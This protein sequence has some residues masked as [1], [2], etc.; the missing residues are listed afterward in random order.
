ML[1]L[2]RFY[3]QKYVETKTWYWYLP[4]LL[5]AIYA[6][7]VTWD[8]ELGGMNPLLPAMVHNLNF[9]FH[10]M[11]HIFTFFLPSILTAAAGSAIELFIP[12]FLIVTSLLTKSY[13]STLIGGWWLVLSTQSVADYVADARSQD[14]ILFTPGG[15][16]AVHDWNYILGQLNALEYDTLIATILRIF[17]ITVYVITILFGIW[18]MYKMATTQ[19]TV[20]SDKNDNLASEVNNNETQPAQTGI[21]P[22]PAAHNEAVEFKAKQHQNQDD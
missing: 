12:L 4:P 7:V 15:G 22:V 10:E 20:N 11:A 1:Y 13:F 17:G 9:V 2:D 21:Y 6:L 18:L 8:F 16:V 19:K 5:F 3:I 14:L